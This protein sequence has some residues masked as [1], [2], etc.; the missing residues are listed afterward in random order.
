MMESVMD[1]L[2]IVRTW[3]RRHSN[4][5]IGV[6]N[7]YRNGTFSGGYQQSLGIPGTYGGPHGHDYATLTQAQASADRD[8][9]NAGHHCDS[10]CG[11]WHELT[12]QNVPTP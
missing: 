3:H 12:I 1:D 7:G 4:G 6:V 11:E 5:S 8:A 9:S 2:D 10:R